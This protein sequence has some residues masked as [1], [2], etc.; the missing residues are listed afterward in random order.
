MSEAASEVRVSYA[1]YLRQERLELHKHEWIDGEVFAMVGGT[2]EH[3]RLTARLTRLVGNAIEGGPCAVYSGDLRIRSRA[4]NIA[5]YADIAVVCGPLQT[6]PEDQDAAINTTLLIEVL[7]PSTELYDRG[8]KA[9]HYR[10]IPSVR[11]YV[12]V[13]QRAPRIE[14]YRRGDAGRWEFFEA[15]SGE[16]IT[17]ESIGCTIAVDELYA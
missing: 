8:D 4:T 14:I 16:S 5:T 13:A 1:E 15:E 9:L 3:A 11:E 10:R 17:F 12:L 6:D 7:S 2:P